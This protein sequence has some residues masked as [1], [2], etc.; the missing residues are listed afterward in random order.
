VKKKNIVGLWVDEMNH[1]NKKKV[2]KRYPVL[3]WFKRNQIFF[4]VSSIIAVPLIITISYVVIYIL[5]H[6]SNKDEL[7]TIFSLIIMMLGIPILFCYAYLLDQVEKRDIIIS[8]LILIVTAMF[9]LTA[10]NIL[11]DLTEID[12]IPRFVTI[13]LLLDSYL[14][15][16]LFSK[17]IYRFGKFIYSIIFKIGQWVVDD[18]QENRDILQAKLSFINKVITGFLAI[19]ASILGLILT[20]NQIMN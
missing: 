15:S 8:I 14:F 4:I 18:K 16:F 20:L 5:N 7:K 1:I 3:E 12:E 9:N 6:V 11:L 13:I 2:G 10:M 17:L 19:V